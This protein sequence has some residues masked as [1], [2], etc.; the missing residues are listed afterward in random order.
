MWR[1]DAARSACTDLRLSAELRAAWTLRLPALEPAWQEDVNQDR[2]PYDA[3]YEPVVVGRRLVVC[4]SRNDSVTAY[5]TR[6]GGVLW[7][8]YLDAPVRL[9]PVAVGER[10]FVV[11]D[12]GRLHALSLV[13]G[14]RLGSVRGGLDDRLVMGNG[15]LVSPWCAR[16]GPVALGGL[17]CF[18]A[19]IWPFMGTS[20]YAVDPAS[21]T[22]VWMND[23]AGAQFLKQPHG[24]SESFGGIAPQGALAGVGEHLLVPSGR[25]VPGRFRT[26]DGALEYFHLDGSP[27]VR[28]APAP[29]R[30][31]EGASQI[32][33]NGTFHV[34]WRALATI[35]Y[36]SATGGG[37]LT[38]TGRHA[39]L[40]TKDWLYL[41]GEKELLAFDLAKLEYQSYET[42]VRVAK[43]EETRAVTRYRWALE[44]VWK[45]DL[46]SQ[47]AAMLAGGTLY[48][49]SESR[50]RA[51]RLR[52]E[53]PPEQVWETS[54]SG[55]V[56]SLL[57]ADGRLF[58]VTREGAIHAFAE[59][60]EGREIDER[61]PTAVE[62]ATDHAVEELAGRLPVPEGWCVV[63]GAEEPTRI[64]AVLRH[65]RLR[66]AA[67]CADESAALRLRRHFDGM[68]LYGAR[69]SV[70]TGRPGAPALPPYFASLVVCGGEPSEEVR[71][72]V[73]RTLRPYGGL[74]WFPECR[75]LPDGAE[76]GGPEFAREGFGG[77][78]LVVRPNALPGAASWTHLHGDMRN[79]AKSDDT[80]VRLPLGLLWF[81]GNSHKDTLPR[82]AH[83][84]SEVVT[85]GRLFLQGTST[86]S[87]RDVYT[88][89]DLWKRDFGD[90][91]TFGIYYDKSHDPDPMD[92]SYNQVHIPG[93]NA[94]GTNMVAA[95]DALYLLRK[96]ECLV[97]DPATGTTVAAYQ[98][99]P[100]QEGGPAPDWVY[101]GV[102]G[103]WLIA[104][105]DFVRFSREP[106]PAAD[107]QPPKPPGPFDTYDRTSCRRLL[108]LARDTGAVVW[109]RTAEHA[110]RHSAICVG[111]ETLFCL[112]AVPP[113]VADQRRRRGEEAAPGRLL[114]LGLA[115]GKLRWENGEKVFGTWLAY[116][117]E[118]GLLVQ[119]GRASRDMLRGEPRDRIAVFRAASGE[120]V[121]DR[122]IP[123]GGP[124]MIHGD[125]IILP[126]PSGTGSALEILTGD[127]FMVPHP[128][129]GEAE[130]WT[131]F[132]RY[133]CN[134][135]TAA[136][137]LL[138][139][140]SGAAGFCDLDSLDGTGNFGGF[141]SGC[142]TN[143]IAAEG[144]LNAP[145]YTRTCTCSY[146]NQASLALVHTPDVVPWKA[147]AIAYDSLESTVRELGLNLAAP[148]DRR[149]AEGMLWFEYPATGGPSPSL[150]VELSLE[151]VESF[152]LHPSR[153]GGDLAWVAASGH[154]GLRAC[155][156][157]IRDLDPVRRFSVRVKSGNDD[158]EEI[159]GNL[160]LGSSDLELTRDGRNEQTVAIRFAGVPVAPGDKILSA[161]IRFT[162]KTPSEEP[163]DLRIHAL[164]SGDALAPGV[165]ARKRLPD[166]VSWQP[167]PWRKAE[168]SGKEQ[169]TPDLTE[170][171]RQV[172]AQPEWEVGGAVVFL[173]EGSGHR[174]AYSANGKATAA[175]V[176]EVTC[177][178][179]QKIDPGPVVCDV[180][181]VMAEPRADV[182]PGQRRFSVAVQGRRAAEVDLAQTPGPR[183]AK[184]IDIPGVSVR[185]WLEI[186]LEPLPGSELPPVLCGVRVRVR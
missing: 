83:G 15:R 47:D 107:G 44:P 12:D 147:N 171:L 2:M 120:T 145:D 164:A 160:N 116:S 179:R 51:L 119:C 103:P 70:R 64:E 152:Q 137:H 87:A 166:V 123:H 65:T 184:G 110:F 178:R 99:P 76:L 60:G 91:G 31:L 161:H 106:T 163:T 90:L 156:I 93:A 143:L 146:Q 127:P 135:V 81:G 175:A 80:R 10:I 55:V 35:L 174:C 17:L 132:R 144:V 21:L 34:N 182:R 36:D 169:T 26:D 72:T 129:S 63:F 78:T 130:R 3:C 121:W 142:S 11:C 186:G 52:P 133:G 56:A 92:T 97:L 32:T 131:Y 100:E 6:T 89:M 128:I 141:K 61:P 22:P 57:A 66:V 151:G 108:V 153:M 148:G 69:V 27:P 157:R 112:D 68:G 104:G 102:V 50:I 9:P 54:V 38:W 177:E 75:E 138:T 162:A 167:E 41:G 117:R 46:P 113:A 23:E 8:S 82:H 118:H 122:Q 39:P 20:L 7:R 45:L 14:A 74:A 24:G 29:S 16:G 124:V 13:D 77:G 109:Q 62:L 48:V 115:D 149:D 159:E 111:G 37:Y 86:L 18:G 79:T 19:G 58:A 140:R 176:L 28:Q 185:E 139:F 53:G 158:G 85:G 105:A 88:G 73:G 101:V 173:V 136:E 126:A 95:A 49:A 96:Q 155:R 154:E 84:P 168:D 43:T 98:L 42:T 59:E 25:S 40:L 134:S 183:T 172:V 170:L 4:S 165:A 71:R 1:A 150:P 125:R 180:Q 181:L 114:A 33:C 94:R 30:K 5:D 67:F